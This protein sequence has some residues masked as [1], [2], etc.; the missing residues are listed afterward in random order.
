MC[1][2]K[3]FECKKYITKKDLGTSFLVNNKKVF[4][5]CSCFLKE[6]K[7]SNNGN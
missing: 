3:C 6:K 7:K 4:M 1:A 2:H 5:H